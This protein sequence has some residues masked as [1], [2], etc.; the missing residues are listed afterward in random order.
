KDVGPK[1]LD[2]DPVGAWDRLKYQLGNLFIYG[3]LK[4]TLGFTRVRVGYTAGEAGEIAEDIR[5]QLLKIDGVSKV[6]IHGQQDERVYVEFDNAQLAQVGLSPSDLRGIL[7]STNIIASGGE[8]D[9]G[10][11][12]I[13][14]EPTGNF[15]S[16]EELKATLV[17]LPSGAVV[18]LD[19]FTTIY[20]DYVDPRETLI[21]HKGEPAIVLAV[22]MSDQDNLLK[23][24]SSVREFFNGLLSVY[25]HGLDFEVAYFQPTDV[26]K[27]IDDFLDSV[28]QAVLI[29]LVVMLVSLGIRTG[30][31]VSTLIPSAMVA[32]IAYLGVVDESI[33]QMSLAALII[34]LGLLVD[35]A[36]V[37]SE[38]ILV[39]LGQGLSHFDAAVSSCKE[40]QTPLLISSL[41][42]AA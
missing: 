21:T 8:I 6:G 39:R 17:T 35:N 18:S 22:Y 20:R 11:E 36:I 1:L 5:D 33:N 31:I 26:E 13:P 27:K 34:A 24:G 19:S 40:L 25:P 23:V 14:L 42:T 7:A 3:P 16:V 2:G 37:V 41:T 15:N 12:T 32:A 4:N 29:V 38:L 30:L 28:V 9:V 10:V